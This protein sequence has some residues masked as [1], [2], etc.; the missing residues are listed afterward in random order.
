MLFIKIADDTI[1]PAFPDFEK[2]ELKVAE[3]KAVGK[4]EKADKLLKFKLDAG[5]DGERQIVSGIAKWYPDF[6]KLVGKKVIIVANLKPIKLRGELSQGMILSSE[7]A[8][9][10]IQVVTVDPSLEN[11]S[12]LA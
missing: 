9:G 4:V 7:K 5:D 8:N 11:G 12:S 2:V 1:F 10:D 6:E 3:I